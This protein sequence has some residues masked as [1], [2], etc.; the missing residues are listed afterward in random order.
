MIRP[1]HLTQRNAALVALVCLALLVAGV[2]VGLG[3]LLARTRYVST[4]V[5]LPCASG[6]VHMQTDGRG[7]FTFACEVL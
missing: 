4:P 7:G 2:L 3:V 6:V 1:I 5:T